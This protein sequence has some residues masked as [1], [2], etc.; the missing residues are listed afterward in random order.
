MDEEEEDAAWLEEDEEGGARRGLMEMLRVER[1]QLVQELALRRRAPWPHPGA[2]ALLRRQWQGGVEGET[3]PPASHRADLPA[4]PPTSPTSPTAPTSP[5]RPRRLK[6]RLEEEENRWRQAATA[7]TAATAAPP[8]QPAQLHKTG[9]T[10]EVHVPSVALTGGFPREKSS[11][12][13]PSWDLDSRWSNLLTRVSLTSH[14]T[15]GQSGQ[16]GHSGHSGQSGQ[17]QGPSAPSPP[18]SARS[19]TPRLA[20]EQMASLQQLWTEQRCLA[21]G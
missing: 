3:L 11:P 15:E 8:V 2:A 16:S 18:L 21:S 5:P 10:P 6:E 20:K 9:Q 13:R 4:S 7:A 19:A 1:R 14:G 17:L 12:S